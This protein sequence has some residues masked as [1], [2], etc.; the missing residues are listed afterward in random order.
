MLERIKENRVMFPFLAPYRMTKNH[1]IHSKMLNGEDIP[2]PRDVAFEVTQK[3]NLSCIMCFQRL[4]KGKDKLKELSFDEIKFIFEERLRKFNF[5]NCYITGSEMFMRKDIKNILE[6]ITNQGITITAQTNGTL[7]TEPENS[8]LAAFRNGVKNIGTSINGL[9]LTDGKIRGGNDVF[10]KTVEGIKF[11]RKIG[12]NTTVNIVVME[13]NLNEIAELVDFLSTTG[14]NEIFLQLIVTHKEAEA[15]ESQTLL[16]LAED[17]LYRVIAPELEFVSSSADV[18]K[19]LTEAVSVGKNKGV[20]SS[21]GYCPRACK[22]IKTP[23]IANFY[24]KDIFYRTLRNKVALSCSSFYS[25]RIAADGSVI[26]CPYIRKEF[27]NLLD[28]PLADIWNSEEFR[29]FRKNL[30]SANMLPTCVRCGKLRLRK[31]YI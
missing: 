25:I 13:N 1:W 26:H 3:C 17:E 14:V 8:F 11:L 12:I 16:S 21:K 19:I 15:E 10:R 22:V 30:L 7:V 6:I 31:Q 20:T 4:N 29:Q 24:F 27:G 5:G 9:S 2:M 23:L 18:D 28:A